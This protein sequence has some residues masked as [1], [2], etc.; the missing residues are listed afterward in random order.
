[1]S[2]YTEYFKIRTNDLD[3]YDKV[4]PY[5]YLDFFQDVAGHHADL[6]GV[7]Y[8]ACKKEN[9]AWVL[10]KNKLEIISSP[11]PYEEVEVV[12]WPS[13]RSRVDYGR[14]YIL[15]NK[16]G[17]VLVKATSQW[18]FADIVTHRIVRTSTLSMP[19]DADEEPLYEEKIEKVNI[20]DLVITESIYSHKIVNSDLDHYGHTNNSR[21]LQMLFDAIP[22]NIDKP[23]KSIVINYLNE[24]HLGEVVE[25]YLEIHDD[26]IIGY[27]KIKDSDK[28]SFS[29]KVLN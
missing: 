5:V 23:F 4:K 7:G 1:M 26:S 12:T 2:K 29:F 20:D 24:A 10:M 15:K 21:Y 6:L 3:T 25:L 27:G 14:D 9:L 17:D 18:V 22:N 28:T 11:L 8:E 19:L 13:S 16:Q